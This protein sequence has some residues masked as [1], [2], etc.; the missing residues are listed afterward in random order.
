MSKEHFESLMQTNMVVS[1]VIVGFVAIALTA[2]V[3]AAFYYG[4]KN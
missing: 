2:V 3:V 4:R 1:L